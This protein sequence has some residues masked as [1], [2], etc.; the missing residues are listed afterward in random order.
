MK[1]AKPLLVSLTEA[2]FQLSLPRKDVIALIREGDL[3]AVNVRG[4][5]LVAFDSLVEFTR[6]AKRNRVVP[7]EKETSIS[8]QPMFAAG[9][10]T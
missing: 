2:E 6:R 10:E 9:R 3:V 7:G 5:I 8:A 4:Q 1:T